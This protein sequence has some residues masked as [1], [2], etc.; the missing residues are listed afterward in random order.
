MRLMFLHLPHKRRVYGLLKPGGPVGPI[1]PV[2]R[3]R[4]LAFILLHLQFFIKKKLAAITTWRWRQG[5]VVD[6]LMLV[7]QAFP[8]FCAPSWVPIHLS[9]WGLYYPFTAERDHHLIICTLPRRVFSPKSNT[10]HF[11]NADV[12]GHREKYFVSRTDTRE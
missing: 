9:S 5:L 12:I 4:R 11:H 10:Y 2:F 6:L 7:L 1:C 8:R 3:R